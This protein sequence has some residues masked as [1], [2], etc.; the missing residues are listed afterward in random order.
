MIWQRVRVALLASM[1]TMS[2]ALPI[3][4]SGKAHAGSCGSDCGAAPGQLGSLVRWTRAFHRAVEGFTHPGP[5]R[6]FPVPGPTLVGHNDIAP[7][8]LPQLRIQ[9]VPRPRERRRYRNGARALNRRGDRSG[10]RQ[11]EGQQERIALESLRNRRAADS[12]RRDD[13]CAG[14]ARHDRRRLLVGRRRVSP[15]GR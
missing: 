6:Y 14:V 9:F 8:H 1:V 3:A 13:W 10:D 11:N 15:V 4:R 7:R 5:W 12:D 2:M